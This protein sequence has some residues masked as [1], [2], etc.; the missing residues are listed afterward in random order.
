MHTLYRHTDGYVHKEFEHIYEKLEQALKKQIAPIVAPISK[1]SNRQASSLI[2]TSIGSSRLNYL[3]MY[4]DY[5]DVI[6]SNIKLIGNI[7]KD[8]MVERVSLDIFE[9]FDEEGILDFH[10]SIGDETIN[11]RLME[12]I[13]NDPSVSGYCYQCYPN[14]HYLDETTLNL[15]F[16]NQLTVTGSG[17]V[18]VYFS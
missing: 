9:S 18:V 3:E 5:N 13:Q 10:V 4:F 15:Y 12:G 14:Y 17:R 2:Y 8:A 16:T 6:A 7:P 1:Q 11:D